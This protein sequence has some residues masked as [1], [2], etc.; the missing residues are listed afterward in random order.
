MKALTALQEG[1]VASVVR[2]HSA[3]PGHHTVVGANIGATRSMESPRRGM[4]FQSVV[5]QRHPL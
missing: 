4:S 1:S 2:R 3:G 5:G